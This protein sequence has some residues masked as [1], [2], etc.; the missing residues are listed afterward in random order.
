MASTYSYM[1]RTV[2]SL[3]LS[4]HVVCG[5]NVDST[6]SVYGTV[7]ADSKQCSFVLQS[8]QLE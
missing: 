3:F 7:I 2:V 6:F 1:D 4:A 5:I 8:Y